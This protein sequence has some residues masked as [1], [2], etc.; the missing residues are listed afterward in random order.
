MNKTTARDELAMLQRIL[1]VA[2]RRLHIPPLVLVTWG[3]CAAIVNAVHQGRALGFPVPSDASF[4]LPLM[5]VAIALTI[6]AARRYETQRETLVDSH[7]GITFGVAFTVALLLNLTAQRTVLPAPAMALFWSGS[8]SIALLVVGIQASRPLLAGGIAL[9]AAS[10]LAVF[11]PGW[12]SGTL[13]LGWLA[14]LA[15]PGI[16]LW[17]RR[18]DA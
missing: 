13:A 3:L 10:V 18:A 9:L 2:D 12:F 11:V 15:V 4:H 1:H 7:A 17:N 5:L 8:I 16:V 14:G 6:W